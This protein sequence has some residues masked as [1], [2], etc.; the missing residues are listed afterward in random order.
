MAELA[1]AG[2]TFTIDGQSVFLRSGEISYYRCDPQTWEHRLREA[3]AANLNCVATY[4]PWAW[5]EPTEGQLDFIGTTHPQRNLV[6]F[7]DLVRESGLYLYARPGPFINSEFRLGGHPD[8]VF[9]SYPQ[10]RSKDAAGRPAIWRAHGCPVPSQLH[11]DFLRLVDRWFDAVIPRLSPYSAE[12]GGP[13]I[14]AQPDNEVNLCFSYGLGH[15]LYDAHSIGD[16]TSCGLWQDWLLARYGSVGAVAA[17]HGVRAGRP[18]ELLPPVADASDPAGRRLISDWLDY[19]A[20]YVFTYTARLIQ[21][22]RERGLRVPYTINEPLNMLF[23][24]GDHAAASEFFAAENGSLFTSGHLYLSGGEQDLIGVPITLYRLELLKL[25]SLAGP[26]FE[27]EMGS[28]WVDLT[29]NR[30]HSN[31][32]LLTKLALGHGLDG[33]NIYMF[34]GGVNPPGSN[35]YGR[36][37]HWNAPVLPDGTRHPTFID[38]QRM[39]SWIAGWEPEISLTEKNFDFQLALSTDLVR[40]ARFMDP[41]EVL[42]PGSEDTFGYATVAT[43]ASHDAYH[44]VEGLVR[45]ATA[46]NA[47]FQFVNL[48][49]PPPSGLLPLP[50]VVPNG[51][52][53]SRRALEL[54]A[55][56]LEQGHSV[57][58]YPS[59]PS[60]DIDG[61]DISDLLERLGLSDI[62][63]THYPIGGMSDDRTR[64]LTV[65]TVPYPEVAVERG[66]RTFSGGQVT[67]V[68]WHHGEVAGFHRQVGAGRLTVLGIYP[69]Y[70][71]RDTQLMLSYLLRDVAGISRNAVTTDDR[72][73]AVVRSRA[74]APHRMVTVANIAGGLP[75]AHVTIDRGTPEE[76]TF[77]VVGELHLDPKTVLNLWASLPLP[78]LT[79]VYS[80]AELY[81]HD[82]RRQTF[83]ARGDRLAPVE[84]AF[85]RPAHGTWDGEPY[86]TAPVGDVHVAT[87]TFT[88][89]ESLLTIQPQQAAQ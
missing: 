74:D 19:K 37:F 45:A 43:R 77:P 7:L 35:I 28:G 72:I 6:R 70:F 83:T 5:H 44:G 36:D 8:W 11:P 84:L 53:L 17:R 21:G 87:L 85:D 30:A 71:T 9:S 22:M 82:A 34:S 88:S 39:G 60:T 10:V 27:A 66:V 26:T 78:G 49:Y 29:R 25:S 89:G 33:Y 18:V 76:L 64:F 65:D 50:V 68:L 23:M 46:M 16:G 73:H 63:E 80:T 41:T 54:I 48:S 67:P 62:K 55:G 51:G 56:H 3:V 14:I 79:L 12:H 86:Q 38:L 32:A 52:R 59:I 20:W 69:S 58:L 47:H 31:F 1:L 4:V 42:N 24:G 13:L 61:N 15:S 81:P 2:K 75:N 40:Q 57:I